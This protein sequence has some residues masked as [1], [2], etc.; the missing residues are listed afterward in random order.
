V[1]TPWQYF[2]RGGSIVSVTPLSSGKKPCLYQLNPHI[3]ERQQVRKSQRS[4]NN[5]LHGPN[6]LNEPHTESASLDALKIV[7]RK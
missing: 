5:C 1:A 4:H 2:D 7:A 3:D 6:D